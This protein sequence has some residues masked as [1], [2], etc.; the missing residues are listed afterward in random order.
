MANHIA[1]QIVP[2]WAASHLGK[3]VRFLRDYD[4]Y[5][6]GTFVCA[7]NAQATLDAIQVGSV[8]PEAVVY[9]DSDPTL[10]VNVPLSLVTHV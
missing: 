9:F 7:V 3:R 5:G 10:Y 4:F 8:E 2:Q 1:S 6:D